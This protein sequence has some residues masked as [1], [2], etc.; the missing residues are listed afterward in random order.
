M[1]GGQ[2]FTRS[3]R[4]QVTDWAAARATAGVAELCIAGDFNQELRG[5]GPVGSRAGRDVF[6]ETLEAL[7]LLCVTGGVRDPLYARMA[8][9]YR[10]QPDQLRAPCRRRG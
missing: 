8:N 2:A 6:D 3:L 10:S 1:P 5:C 7:E 9:E 4:L